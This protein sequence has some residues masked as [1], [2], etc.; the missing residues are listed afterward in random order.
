[1]YVGMY[2]YIDICMYIY[3]HTYIPTYNPGCW[4][5]ALVVFFGCVFSAAPRRAGGMPTDGLQVAR[6]GAAAHWR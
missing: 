2:A 1:M 3:M 4:L 6:V 5:S